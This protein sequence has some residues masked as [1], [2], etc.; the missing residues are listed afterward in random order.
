MY[1]T[2]RQVVDA[3]EKA[4][5]DRSRITIRGLDAVVRHGEDTPYVEF[6]RQEFPDV[7]NRIFPYIVTNRMTN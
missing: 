3:M 5:I 2:I 4:G 6:I 7:W 1:I